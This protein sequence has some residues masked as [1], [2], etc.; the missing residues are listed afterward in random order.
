MPIRSLPQPYQD[1]QYYLI[2]FNDKGIERTDDPDGLMSDLIKEV[3]KNEPIT[4][5]FLISHGWL[6][7]IPAAINQY[8]AW[9]KAMADNQAD[10]EK[11]KKIRPDFKPLMIGIHWP[12]KPLG[13]EKL[14]LTTDPA[15]TE[16]LTEFDEQVIKNRS[17]VQSLTSDWGNDFGSGEGLNLFN[18][19]KQQIKQKQESVD[20]KL[21]EFLSYWNMKEL[22]RQIGQTS[23]FDLLTK[24]QNQTND[25]VR[26]H[27]IGHSFG[28]IVVSAMLRGSEVDSKL[29]RPVN[30]L[31]LIQG[32]VSLWSFCE[33]VPKRDNLMGYFHPIVSGNK[34]AGPIITTNSQHDYSVKK[35]Y[36]LASRIGL[37]TRHQDID[38]DVSF[39]GNNLPVFGG[40]GTYGIQGSGLDIYDSLMK[41]TDKE[42]NFKNGSIY[43]LAS[44][45][46]IKDGIKDAHSA[47]NKTEVAHAVWS[48]VFG[49]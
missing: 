37:K 25:Q 33:K 10:I 23:G 40:I 38:F 34:V 14:E 24:L 28:T 31:S 7:D 2:A 42:Y 16:N 3:L 18:Y 39:G 22:A 19:I 47:I 30:S 26:F 1:I 27:L 5:V 12:S 17:S 6:G 13:D 29:V 36:P 48:A 20:K 15:K 41:T 46:F 32:A 35:M 11:I 9:I 43:N 49:S 8:D 4:D 21:T 44:D 45:N